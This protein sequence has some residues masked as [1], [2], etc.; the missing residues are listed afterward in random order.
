MPEAKEEAVELPQRPDASVVIHGAGFR[1]MSG[2]QRD[3]EGKEHPIV[4]LILNVGTIQLEIP[5]APDSAAKLNAGIS[6]AVELISK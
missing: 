1:V 5:I 3:D 2:T 4:I 6:E